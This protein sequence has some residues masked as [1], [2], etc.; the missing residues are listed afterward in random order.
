MRGLFLAAGPSLVVFLVS[1]TRN[2]VLPIVVLVPAAVIHVT[3][4]SL[5]VLVV[6][7]VLILVILASFVVELGI[8]VAST[9]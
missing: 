9:A 7:I 1:P 2:L 4:S 6:V 5:L 8:V 3:V